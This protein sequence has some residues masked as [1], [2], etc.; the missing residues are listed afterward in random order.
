MFR[1][2][3]CSSSGGPHKQLTVFCHASLSVVL[4][5]TQYDW[6]QSYQVSN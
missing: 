1:T 5:L 3:N 2:N 4:S 6:Y